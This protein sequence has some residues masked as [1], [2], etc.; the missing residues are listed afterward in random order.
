M[1]LFCHWSQSV[2]VYPGLLC[3]VVFGALDMLTRATLSHSRTFPHHVST[4][5]HQNG[6]ISAPCAESTKSASLFIHAVAL[7]RHTAN[8]GLTVSDGLPSRMRYRDPCKL[9]NGLCSL[10]DSGFPT[11]MEF[12]VSGMFFPFFS[13]M[14]TT[15]LLHLVHET[16]GD[17]RFQL[18][19]LTA[20]R[21]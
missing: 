20:V 3:G 4:T 7:L 12:V 10:I 1:Y 6:R 21:H 5:V 15:S 11:T 14:L 8:V 18:N 2:E 19:S 13:S 9:H 17:L 16:R